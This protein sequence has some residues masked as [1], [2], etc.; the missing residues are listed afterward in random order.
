LDTETM[1]SVGTA[2]AA[3]VDPGERSAPGWTGADGIVGTCDLDSGKRGRGA[4][5][6]V[7]HPV[8]WVLPAPV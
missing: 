4:G 6:V 2:P 5:R 8:R 7:G 3:P 1:A